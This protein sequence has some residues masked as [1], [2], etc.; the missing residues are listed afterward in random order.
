MS[1]RTELAKIALRHINVLT[2]V[3]FEEMTDEIDL[4][5]TAVA[6]YDGVILQLLFPNPAAGYPK[7]QLLKTDISLAEPTSYFQNEVG[8]TDL[9]AQEVILLVNR[10]VQESERLYNLDRRPHG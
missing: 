1:F 5:E 2:L 9:T 7:F 3:S 10:Y 4:F 6:E 8:E